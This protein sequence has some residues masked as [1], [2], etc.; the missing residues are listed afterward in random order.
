[1]ATTVADVEEKLLFGR[2]PTRRADLQP[3]DRGLIGQSGHW[4]SN[5]SRSE[6]DITVG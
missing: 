6:E 5:G 4:I 2:Q 3:L 1:M